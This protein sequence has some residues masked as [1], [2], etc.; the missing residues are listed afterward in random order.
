MLLGIHGGD[1]RKLP[2]EAGFMR[3]FRVLNIPPGTYVFPFFTKE[4][5]KNR[6]AMEEAC[7]E[8]NLVGAGKPL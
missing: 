7:K 3:A 8:A 6:A 4:M 5:K 2:D 1:Y